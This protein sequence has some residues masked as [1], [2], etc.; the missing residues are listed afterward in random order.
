MKKKVFAI[1]VM[2]LLG[3]TFLA[4]GCAKDEAEPVKEEKEEEKQEKEEPEEELKA[5]GVEEGS[6]FQ[7][8]L[9]NSTGKDIVGVSV[10]TIETTEYPANMLAN[11]DTYKAN[12]SR[13][14]YYKAEKAAEDDAAA[15]PNAKVLTPGYDIQLTFVDNSVAELHAFPFGDIEKGEL[16]FADEVA[17]VKYTSVSSKEE[18]ETKE[19]ELAIVTQKKAEAEAKAVAE[20]QAAADAQNDYSSDNYDY[21]QDYS[22]DYSQDYSEDYSQDYSEDYS[23][24]YSQG[25]SSGGTGDGCVGDGLVY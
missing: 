15:D 7:V 8:E 19:A 24:D 1:V 14:L 4:S 23:Q 9:K 10:K 13:N 6:D 16:C 2:C 3:I 11:G 5:I 25:D 12:E 20:E 17:Y 18:I 22:E 21:S